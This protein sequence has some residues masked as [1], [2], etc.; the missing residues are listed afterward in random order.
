[1]LIILQSFHFKLDRKI[2]TERSN[3]FPQQM[4]ENTG[5]EAH[6]TTELVSQV[7]ILF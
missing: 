4:Q 2:Y 5:T 7:N 3:T 1:M 6:A